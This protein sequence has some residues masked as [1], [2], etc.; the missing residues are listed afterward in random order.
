MWYCFVDKKFRGSPLNHKNHEK[1]TPRKIPAIRYCH[2][3]NLLTYVLTL[4]PF[5]I[6]LFLCT[7][8]DSYFV[9]IAMKSNYIETDTHSSC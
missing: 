5:P 3:Y 8:C 7:C 1:F 6:S 4:P 9:H 2:N